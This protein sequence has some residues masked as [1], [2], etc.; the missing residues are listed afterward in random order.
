MKTFLFAAGQ[1]EKA[2]KNPTSAVIKRFTARVQNLPQ[3]MVSKTSQETQQDIY[4]VVLMRLKGNFNLVNLLLLLIYLL[5][6]I[7]HS[8]SNL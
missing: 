2:Q 7:Q 8:L 1:A 4:Q 3:S 5:R 6:L